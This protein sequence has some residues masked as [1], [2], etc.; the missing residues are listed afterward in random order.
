M[1]GG[2]QEFGLR[3]GTENLAGCAGFATALKLATASHA[4][5]ARRLSQL[6]ESFEAE[7]LKTVPGA[8]INGSTKHRAP[9]ITS[10]TIEGVD[11][12]RL[13]FELDEQGIQCAVGSACSASSEEPSHVLEA[14]GLSPA[15]A[16]STLRFSFG[17]HTTKNQLQKTAKTLAELTAN[18]R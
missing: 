15:M 9:H 5:E 12:E 10:L 6:R 2:G 17:K 3:S 4:D 16:Q 11:N 1:R 7:I 13:M 18:N 14:I 8:S